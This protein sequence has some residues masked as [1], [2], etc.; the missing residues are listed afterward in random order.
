MYLTVHEQSLRKQHGRNK[1]PSDIQ[2][3][4]I[5][6]LNQIG[7]PS[8]THEESR[9]GSSCVGWLTAGWQPRGARAQSGGSRR[10]VSR[11]GKR[12]ADPEAGN[13]RVLK[14]LA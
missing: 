10:P 14:S 8:H 3:Q 12:Q 4:T 13:D 1:V 9:R 6:P 7:D 2:S 11:P 5:H